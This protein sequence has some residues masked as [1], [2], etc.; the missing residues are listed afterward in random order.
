MFGIHGNFV[1]C[2]M[3]GE[4]QIFNKLR[5]LNCVPNLGKGIIG[6]KGKLLLPRVGFQFVG[7][8]ILG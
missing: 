6:L 8:I 4:D 5:T 1:H 7:I 2:F 3:K